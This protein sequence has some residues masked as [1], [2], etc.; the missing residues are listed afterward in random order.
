MVFIQKV[1][2]RKRP[3]HEF[4][5]ERHP[6]QLS[7]L[8]HAPH[9]AEGDG[10]RHWT[11][12]PLPGYDYIA[13]AGS[14][15]AYRT[16][17]GSV[18]AHGAECGQRAARASDDNAG[19]HSAC[20]GLCTCTHVPRAAAACAATTATSSRVPAAAAAAPSVPPDSGCPTAPA[21]SPSTCCPTATAVSPGARR[22]TAAAGAGT[23]AFPPAAC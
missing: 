13:I 12:S 11:L 5:P 9:R 20:T 23:V 14:A 22:P 17:P 16:S 2:R 6:L 18:M 3:D 4:T 19:A 21:V 7:V 15:L 10:R 8:R 1:S